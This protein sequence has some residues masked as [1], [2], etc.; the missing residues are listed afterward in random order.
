[1]S[2]PAHIP[3][4]S[5]DG[6]TRHRVL[7]LG[8]ASGRNLGTTSETTLTLTLTLAL[9]LTEKCLATASEKTTLIWR[10]TCATQVMSCQGLNSIPHILASIGLS[11]ATPMDGLLSAWG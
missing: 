8:S 6:T 1:M 7:F 11:F 10:P 2:Y 4:A 9:G 3:G 5:G